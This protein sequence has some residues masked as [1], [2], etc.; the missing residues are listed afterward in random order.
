MRSSLI[1]LCMLFCLSIKASDES[2]GLVVKS[3]D[4]FTFNSYNDVDIKRIYD[5][6]K[7]RFENFTIYDSKVPCDLRVLVFYSSEDLLPDKFKCIILI[8]DYPDRKKLDYYQYSSTSYLFGKIFSK[9][10]D[11]LQEHEYRYCYNQIEKYIN[12]WYN[13]MIKFIDKRK[14]GDES[15]YFYSERLYKPVIAFVVT[16]KL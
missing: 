16:N 3:F 13:Q 5:K 1:V 4:K 2:D 15:C 11:S 6:Q 10:L 8:R 7:N 12:K 9:F 14:N